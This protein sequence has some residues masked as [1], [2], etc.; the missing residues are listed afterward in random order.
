MDHD[1]LTFGMISETG[2]TEGPSYYLAK[3]Y[4]NLKD[5]KIF[6]STHVIIV[7]KKGSRFIFSTFALEREPTNWKES[8]I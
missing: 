1:L 4:Q 8:I 7:I 2:V 6:K 3:S 5:K